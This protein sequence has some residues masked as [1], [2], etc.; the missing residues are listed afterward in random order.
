MQWHLN[1]ASL[2]ADPEAPELVPGEDPR[3]GRADQR[4]AHLPQGDP[5]AGVLP[6]PEH[7]LNHFG[8]VVRRGR[9]GEVGVVV[10]LHRNLELVHPGRLLHILVLV[11]VGGGNV[12]SLW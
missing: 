8:T 5:G 10:R 2:P 9:Q 7:D 11:L 6:A 3:R 12:D 1:E 4:L